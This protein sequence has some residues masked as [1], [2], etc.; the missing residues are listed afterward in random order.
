VV[1]RRNT[2][3]LLGIVVSVG[4]LSWWLTG[5]SLQLPGDPLAAVPR[6]TT[7]VVVVD[8]PALR[9]STIWKRLVVDRGGEGGVRRIEELCG[10]DPLSSISKVTAF[11]SGDAPGDLSRV[12]LIGRGRFDPQSLGDCVRRVVEADG[13]ELHRTEIDGVPAVRGRGSS[14]A[15]FIGRD[16]IAGGDE[17]TVQEII[18]AIRGDEASARRDPVLAALWD[19]V[20]AG[21][22][23][24][25]VAHVPEGWRR[26]L[27]ERLRASP[28]TDLGAVAGVRALG[29]GA[30]V[31]SG[32]TTEVVMRMRDAGEAERAGGALSRVLEDTLEAGGIA[33]TVARPI[34]SRLSVENRGS[35]VCATL[36]LDE[37]R[38]ELALD[39]VVALLDPPPPRDRAE[40]APPPEPDEIIR[41]E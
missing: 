20:S 9:E 7:A 25:L 10:G 13:G 21:R 15:A 32:L 8:V 33:V 37:E 26:A 39:I 36:D 28:D 18:A 41:R 40:E 38:L 31:R 4:L 29:V 2:A 34:L 6:G 1:S 19:E 14:R 11:A 12:G 35:E 3:L 17:E 27:R 5:R 23:A 24:I 30:A 22:D 16:G